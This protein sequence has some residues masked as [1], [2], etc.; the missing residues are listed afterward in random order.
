MIFND[1]PTT[2]LPGEYIWRRNGGVITPS[3]TAEM[4]I[5]M[6]HDDEATNINY[7]LVSRMTSLYGHQGRVEGCVLLTSCHPN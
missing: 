7:T 2:L 1:P 5:T 4:I 6:N 3:I